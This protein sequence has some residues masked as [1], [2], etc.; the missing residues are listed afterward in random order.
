MSIWNQHPNYSDDQLRQLVAV[1]SE[2]FLDSDTAAEQFPPDFLEI[3]P[4]MAARQLGPVLEEN[5]Q[6]L[7][8]E[9]VQEVLQDPIPSRDLCIAILTEIKRS[10]ELATRVSETYARRERKMGGPETVLLAG[11]LVV[12]AIKLKELRWGPEGGRISFYESAETVK[13]FLLNLLNLSEHP[14]SP[15]NGK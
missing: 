7:H 4:A 12:L 5:G 3:S 10:P 8:A 14:P 13:A 15:G 9:S 2:V 1:C 6:T 11:A